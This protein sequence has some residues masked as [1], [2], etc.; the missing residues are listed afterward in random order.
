MKKIA[1]RDVICQVKIYITIPS[2]KQGKRPKKKKT[3]EYKPNAMPI[4]IFLGK[5]YF[6]YREIIA[7]PIT[8]RRTVQGWLLYRDNDECIRIYYGEEQT[9]VLLHCHPISRM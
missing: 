8:P 1:N 4:Y 7:L 6:L 9:F 3:R 2:L 5:K